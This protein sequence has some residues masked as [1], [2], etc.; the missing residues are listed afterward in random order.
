V[1]VP[2]RPFQTYLTFMVKARSLPY[3]GPPFR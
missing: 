1:F 2:G 3:N